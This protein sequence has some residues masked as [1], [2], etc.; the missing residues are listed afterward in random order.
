MGEPAPFFSNF[1]GTAERLPNGNTLIVESD[2]GR[3]FE[4]TSAGAIVWEFHNPHRAGEEGEFI[5]RLFDL[6]RLPP[7]FPTAW[8]EPSPGN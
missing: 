6:V 1:C 3:A 4:V 7:E 5:A 8:I 2:N